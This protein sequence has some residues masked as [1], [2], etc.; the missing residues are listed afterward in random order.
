MTRV[1]EVSAHSGLH[2]PLHGDEPALAMAVS[3]FIAC[4]IAMLGFAGSTWAAFI[5]LLLL[6]LWLV[7]ADR[8]RL[9]C[10]GTD[11][12][13]LPSLQGSLSGLAYL[14]RRGNL[15]GRS[16]ELPLVWCGAVLLSS[17]PMLGFITP[18]SAPDHVAACMARGTTASPDAAHAV[19]P[20]KGADVLDGHPGLRGTVTAT[21]RLLG[22]E[23]SAA[24]P[25]NTGCA[26]RPANEGGL[27]RP[28]GDP[29][30]RGR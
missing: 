21:I 10:L 17:V 26:Y 22:S 25:S 9:D 8:V 7:V 2:G 16:R 5:S 3:P 15:L 19:F 14:V 29:R 6:Q 12:T 18:T 13:G 1:P 27:E 28:S 11:T 20:R 4:M 30:E 24:R 23:L